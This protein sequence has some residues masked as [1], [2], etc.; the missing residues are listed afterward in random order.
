MSVTVNNLSDSPLTLTLG[1]GGSL[2]GGLLCLDHSV[3][4][5]TLTAKSKTG[6]AVRFV[7]LLPGVHTVDNVRLTDMQGETHVLVEPWQ[8]QIV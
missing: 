1:I 6:V 5:G 3:V 7:G 2:G 4:L 8:I